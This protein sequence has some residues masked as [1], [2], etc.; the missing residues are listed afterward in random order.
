[1]WEAQEPYLERLRGSLWGPNHQ[2]HQCSEKKKKVQGI[3]AM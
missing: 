1:M 2:A 3:T